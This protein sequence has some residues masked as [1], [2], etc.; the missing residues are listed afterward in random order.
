MNIIDE[1]SNIGIVPVIAIEDTEDARPLAKALIDGG[2][3]CAEITFRTPAAEKAIQI[4]HECFPDMLVGAGTVLNVN[5]VDRAVYA[6][7]K[8]IVSPGFNP[9]IVAYCQE[10]NIPIVPGCS[11]PSD[12][13]AAI[14]MGLDTVKF[15]PAQA[16]GGLEMIKAMSAPYGNVRFMPTGGI[17]RGNMKEYLDFSKVI[18]CGGSW[19]V[20]KEMLEKKDFA[21]IQELTEET[22]AAMLGFELMHVGINAPDTEEAGRIAG[23][24]RNMFSFKLKEGNDS[25]YAGNQIE[26]VK[27]AGLG[28]HGHLAIGVNYLERAI[29]YLGK[30]GYGFLKDTA[31]YD[32]DGRLEAIY[33]QKDA[34]GFAIHLLQK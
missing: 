17:N 26:I 1:I 23:E 21:A 19:M 22:V 4:I 25:V 33:L 28:I 15:F 8:F 18:A 3:N 6:G 5:Q 10:K 24:L 20:K 16:S 31:K 13:E 7:A 27:G 14:E 30:R 2:I 12:I 9:K 29:Y 34:A 32:K 11:G